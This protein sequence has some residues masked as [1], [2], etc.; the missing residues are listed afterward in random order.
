MLYE[1]NTLHRPSDLKPS[2]DDIWT[3]F[4]KNN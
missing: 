3:S 1:I 4:T 2:K